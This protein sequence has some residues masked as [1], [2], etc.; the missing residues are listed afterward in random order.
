MHVNQQ[1]T[2]TSVT[3]ISSFRLPQNYAY[4]YDCQLFLPWKCWV[5]NMGVLS[6]KSMSFR[7]FSEF[8]LQFKHLSKTKT[9]ALIVCHL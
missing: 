1:N 7:I 6:Y 2:F 4:F 9:Y 3:L 8:L 5:I